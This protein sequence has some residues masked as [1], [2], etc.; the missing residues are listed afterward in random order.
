MPLP[1]GAARAP[2]LQ[3]ALSPAHGVLGP[4]AR[5]MRLAL[6][7]ARPRN[8]DPSCSGHLAWCT[9][10]RQGRARSD[11][12]PAPP[13]PPQ[14]GGDCPATNY[15]FMGDF[16]DRGFYSVETFLLLLALKARK[17]GGL[18]R[19]R[20]GA[21]NR[22]GALL[23]SRHA[24]RQTCA[25]YGLGVTAGCRRAH[26]QASRTRLRRPHPARPAA[27]PPRAVHSPCRCATPTA[28]PSSAA[29]TRAG[30]S[31]RC[32]ASTTSACASTAR[33]T[34]GATARTCSTTS[35]GPWGAGRRGA[36]RDARHRPLSGD[37]ASR[38]GPAHDRT[39]P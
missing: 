31:R 37:S 18:C 15:L 33:S 8:M 3:P 7:H 12:H 9:A 32:T 34:C 39:S 11:P 30:R 20:T 19:A 4:R 6:R 23:G 10:P 21:L 26:V 13:T 38:G 36:A 22:V 27:P 28:S 24:R 25:A 1:A 2:R 29:T 17:R 16:V 5:S 14:V 35:G